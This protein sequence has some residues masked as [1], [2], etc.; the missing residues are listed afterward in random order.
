MHHASTAVESV[1]YIRCMRLR[2]LRHSSN[3]LALRQYSTE[4]P[5]TAKPQTRL[6]RARVVL[7]ASGV[8]ATAIY[9]HLT[10][11]RP[12]EGGG[13]SDTR[14]SF[15][16]TT[17]VYT[18]IGMVVSSAFGAMFMYDAGYQFIGTGPWGIVAIGVLGGL[19]SMVGMTYTPP[20][21]TVT[22][23]CFWL[24]S[25]FFPALMLSPLFFTH[26][27][28]YPR[29]ALY[30]AASVCAFSSAGAIATNKQ[31]LVWG[32]TL[33]A[34]ASVLALS[35]FVPRI[36]PEVS[37]RTLGSKEAVYLYGGT[38]LLNAVFIGHHAEKIV[39]D[40]RKIERGR[41]IADPLLTS[42]DNQQYLTWL[43]YNF[44][45]GKLLATPS[46][47][48]FV[49]HSSY[50]PA[51]G[52]CSSHNFHLHLH[53][54]RQGLSSL[55][56]IGVNAARVKPSAPIRH[57]S[58]LRPNILQTLRKQRESLTKLKFPRYSTEVPII[59]TAKPVSWQ[60]VALIAGG[61]AG[62]VVVL[63]SLMNRETRDGL[64]ASERSLLN[65]TFAYTGVGLAITAAAARAMFTS[66]VAFRIMAANPWVVFG[67]SLA[68]G[69]GSMMGVFY[70]PPENTIPKHLFWLT[71]NAFQ[72]ATLSPLFFLNP[73]VLAR[74][75]LYTVGLVGALSYVGA[76]ATNDKY[77]MLGGPLLAGV[78]VVA[79]SAFAPLVLPVTA[80]RTLAVT[81]GLY[82]YGGLAVF[83]GFV[84]YD[85]QKILAHARM[86]EQGRMKADPINEAVGLQL[87]MINI[88]IRLVQILSMNNN[89]R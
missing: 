2:P 37:R 3:R 22:K 74:A 52:G 44:G 34:G 70:T 32:G 73:A 67:A 41:M 85:T 1:A 77:L 23:H 40:S 82:L 4:G 56:P 12:A 19:A 20:E 16:N 71:F 17:F 75:G 72:A 60:R 35:M 76:T 13:F 87:D 10:M 14:R 68:G 63:D 9:T 80:V 58:Q 62:S 89:R 31:Y 33:L 50:K 53:M 7:G 66:G 42:V 51:I 43:G 29:V 45:L 28:F 88:F 6:S 55:R 57:F 36:L 59:E 65:S 83:G 5:T 18:G 54:F 48:A 30:T 27:V 25:N 11:N 84:L 39:K 21:W 81:E 24:T 86:A 61:V 38:A 64:S 69:I 79:L 47:A 8:A 15:I 49:H 78:S 26:P 46:R